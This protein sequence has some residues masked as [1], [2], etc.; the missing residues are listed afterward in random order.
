MLSP[1]MEWRRCDTTSNAHT[2]NHIK[3]QCVRAYIWHHSASLVRLLSLLRLC[4]V[5]LWIRAAMRFPP[6][7][8][9]F[10]S[11]A[12]HSRTLA[13]DNFMWLLLLRLVFMNFILPE[14][15]IITCVWHLFA[16]FV[17]FRPLS[18]F[19]RRSVHLTRAIGSFR[20]VLRKPTHTLLVS[21]VR[22][23][24]RLL[25]LLFVPFSLSFFRS[26][27]LHFLRWRRDD[28]I[29]PFSNEPNPAIESI[30]HN[31]YWVYQMVDSRFVARSAP[32]SYPNEEAEKLRQT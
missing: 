10:Q 18:S 4:Y 21:I 17:F 32:A 8:H 30:V 28:R 7:P 23:A 27:S 29:S 12:W 9:C 24:R 16:F 11:V 3:L 22:A 2:K 20:I 15:I 26:H 19:I 6:H 5:F 13:C 25:L 31:L 14:C 1:R